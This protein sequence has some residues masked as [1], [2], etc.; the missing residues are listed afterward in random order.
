MTHL[1]DFSQNLARMKILLDVKLLGRRLIRTI[2]HK[3]ID[4]STF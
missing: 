3:D 2:Y 1:V 4:V